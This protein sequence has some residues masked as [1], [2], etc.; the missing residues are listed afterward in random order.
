[1]TSGRQLTDKQLEIL[2][3]HYKETFTRLRE[4][5]ALRDRLFLRLIGLFALL[6]IEIGYPAALGGTLGKLSVL[7]GNLIFKR[8]HCQHFSTLLGY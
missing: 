7:G 4:V 6:I 2:H 5:E 1:V 8:Y 3:D